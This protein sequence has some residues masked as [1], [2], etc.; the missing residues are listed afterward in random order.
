MSNEL[1]GDNSPERAQNSPVILFDLGGVIVKNGFWDWVNSHTTEETQREP[2]KQIIDAA[3]A[4]KITEEECLKVLG[5]LSHRLP[6]QVDEELNAAY[7][8]YGDVVEILG[9]LK[10]R[11]YPLVLVTNFMA[12]RANNILDK[13]NLRKF[14]D[15][16]FI[17]S[18]MGL[19]KPSPEFF[20][21]VNMGLGIKSAE[22][23]FIDDSARNI[24][25]AAQEGIQKA[26]QFT[27]APSLRSRFE[28]AHMLSPQKPLQA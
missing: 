5:D 3:D 23:I 8:P 19:I 16:V 21:G 10:E 6:N 13:Y 17:S 4:G 24:E 18:E 7:S 9:E 22:E 20:K 1:T 28:Q 26:W 15:N 25:V 2:Y 27:D 11:G 14:F 12:G